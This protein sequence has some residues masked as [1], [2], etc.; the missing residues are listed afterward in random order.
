MLVLQMICRFMCSS[1]F[2]IMFHIRVP[3][4][5]TNQK[6][7]QIVVR[8]SKGEQN[9]RQS[10]SRVHVPNLALKLSDLPEYAW[11]HLET[12]NLRCTVC[13]KVVTVLVI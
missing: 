8:E 10:K 3:P 4:R 12:I 9:H 2:T 7:A 11:M 6:C 5:I 1:V 13:V